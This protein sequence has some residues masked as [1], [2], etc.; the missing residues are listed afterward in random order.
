MVLQ[1]DIPEKNSG[2]FHEQINSLY[3]V[4]YNSH[5]PFFDPVLAFFGSPGIPN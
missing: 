5:I 2:I 3:G 1:N 4:D